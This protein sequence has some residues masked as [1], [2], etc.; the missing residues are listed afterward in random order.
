M[1]DNEVAGWTR[2]RFVYYRATASAVGRQ[3]HRKCASDL[4]DITNTFIVVAVVVF[5]VTV[6]VCFALVFFVCL[7]VFSQF[8]A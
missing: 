2:A 6:V 3:K 4:R 5:V 7:F 1:G 8:C